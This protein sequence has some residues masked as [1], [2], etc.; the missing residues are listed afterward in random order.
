MFL[1]SFVSI[2]RDFNPFDICEKRFRYLQKCLDVIGTSSVMFGKCR[3]SSEVT[4][5]F[6]KTKKSRL[7]KLTHLTDSRKLGRYTLAW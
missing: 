3:Y 5:T 7:K 2:T 6:S 4:G 1:C